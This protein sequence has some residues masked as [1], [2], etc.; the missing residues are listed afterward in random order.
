MKNDRNYDTLPETLLFS[1]KINRHIPIL[2]VKDVSMASMIS[3]SKM[4]R[5]EEVM[6]RRRGMLLL[7]KYHEMYRI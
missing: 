1:G 3:P 7:F 4:N 2:D 6:G 5:R